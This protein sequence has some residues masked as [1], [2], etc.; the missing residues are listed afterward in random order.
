MFEFT[1]D[2]QLANVRGSYNYVNVSQQTVL[3][4]VQSLQAI[5]KIKKLRQNG[6]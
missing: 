3:L 4:T 6:Q 1:Q 2:K 5:L